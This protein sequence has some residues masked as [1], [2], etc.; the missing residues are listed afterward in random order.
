MILPLAQLEMVLPSF[1]KCPALRPEP[2]RP[3]I[4]ARPLGGQ[5]RRSTGSQSSKDRLPVALMHFQMSYFAWRVGLE[6]LLVV[7]PVVPLVELEPVPI[8][9]KTVIRGQ[10]F[11]RTRKSI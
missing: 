9:S 8:A 3:I 5:S 2:R 6:E 1:L 7:E 4:N 11:K 10:R